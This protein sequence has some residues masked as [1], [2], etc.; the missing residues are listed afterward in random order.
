VVISSPSGRSTL[1]EAALG[2]YVPGLTVLGPADAVEAG[3]AA[4]VL[5]QIAPGDGREAAYVCRGGACAL[6][7]HTSEQLRDSLMEVVACDV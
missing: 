5:A 1:L 7:V 2:V 3:D 4:L 6:P